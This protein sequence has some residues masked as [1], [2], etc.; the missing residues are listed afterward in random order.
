MR[1]DFGSSAVCQLA[2]SLRL[3]QGPPLHIPS[4]SR[5]QLCAHLQTSTLPPL[6]SLGGSVHFCFSPL[7]SQVQPRSEKQ[8]QRFLFSGGKQQVKVDSRFTNHVP[9]LDRELGLG[10]ILMIREGREGQ[11]VEE[12]DIGEDRAGEMDEYACSLGRWLQGSRSTRGYIPPS[13]LFIDTQC[14]V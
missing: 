1:C 13:F 10:C 4:A 5:A 3:T 2:E 12:A 7:S 8:Q 11:R 6:F 9:R 14:H